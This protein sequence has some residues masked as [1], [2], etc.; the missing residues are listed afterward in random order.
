M[1]SFFIEKENKFSLGKLIKITDKVMLLFI[2]VFWSMIA[3]YFGKTFIEKNFIYPLRYEEIICESSDYYG[4]DRALVFAVVKVES[5]F[6]KD[7]KSSK[8]AIGLM[9][10]TPRTAKYIAKLMKIENY[11]LTDE[12]TNVWFGCFYLKYLID[13]FENIETAICAYNAGEGNVALWLNNKE[14]SKDSKTLFNIPFAETDNYLI[15]FRKTY[16]KYGELYRNILDKTKN[17]E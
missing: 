13:K 1:R 6:N 16:K 15:K 4:L 12:Q 11:D 2:A 8:G 5:S 10:I 14:Y 17:F 9:Q 7:A 3:F